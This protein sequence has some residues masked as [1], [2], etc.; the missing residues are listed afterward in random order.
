[1]ETEKIFKDAA[2][3]EPDNIEIKTVLNY[4]KETNAFR[5]LK[6]KLESLTQQCVALKKKMAT[7]LQQAELF[8]QHDD[9]KTPWKKNQMAHIAELAHQLDSTGKIKLY[10]QVYSFVQVQIFD[11]M[12]L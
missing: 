2:K 12:V 5:K 1:M 11:V 9:I 10:K 8:A 3:L 6:T 4:V 7:T